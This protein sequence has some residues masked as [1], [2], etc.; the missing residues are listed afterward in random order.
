VQE[1][2]SWNKSDRPKGLEHFQLNHNVSKPA[3]S[4][5]YGKTKEESYEIPFMGTMLWD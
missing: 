4:S 2:R 1:Q 3:L 5:T